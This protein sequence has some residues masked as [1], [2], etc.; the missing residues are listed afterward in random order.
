[1]NVVNVVTS[2]VVRVIK[3]K[4]NLEKSIEFVVLKKKKKKQKT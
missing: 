3:N 4:Q 1:M 2:V